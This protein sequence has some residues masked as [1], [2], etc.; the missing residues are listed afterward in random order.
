MEPRNAGNHA[1][2]EIRS[3][4]IAL[5]RIFCVRND[6]NARF[7]LLLHFFEQ[8]PTAEKHIQEMLSSKYQQSDLNR[9]FSR[10][11]TQSRA[12]QG[13]LDFCCRACRAAR[14]NQKPNIFLE[15]ARLQKTFI[16]LAKQIIVC[17]WTWPR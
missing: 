11:I 1:I 15:I 10:P 3:D 9:S 5:N 7:S 6:G 17:L 8:S 4:A 14:F 2:Y 16:G 12:V 13:G